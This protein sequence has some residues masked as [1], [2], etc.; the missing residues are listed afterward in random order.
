MRSIIYGSW[1][2]RKWK[3]VQTKYYEFHPKSAKTRSSQ[4]RW[5]TAKCLLHTGNCNRCAANIISTVLTQQ[6]R[7][8]PKW[9]WRCFSLA[10]RKRQPAWRIPTDLNWNLYA[11]HNLQQIK[12]AKTQFSQW[13]KLGGAPPPL[14]QQ[15]LSYAT[16]DL[17]VLSSSGT[18]NSTN[19]FNHRQELSMHDVAKSIYEIINFKS[20]LDQLYSLYSGSP[21]KLGEDQMRLIQKTDIQN[22][23]D[24]GCPLVS[25]SISTVRASV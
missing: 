16:S 5:Y 11:L 4:R 23:K 12:T 13:R 10:G 22:R 2:N 17:I 20:F 19:C 6:S 1:I 21:V 24:V 14:Y 18:S 15:S 7:G 25:R 8:W 3:A 9:L